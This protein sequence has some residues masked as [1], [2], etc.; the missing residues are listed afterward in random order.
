MTSIMGPEYGRPGHTWAPDADE[1]YN[2]E[3]SIDPNTGQITGPLGSVPAGVALNW[4]AAHDQAVWRRQQQLVRQA[5]YYGQNA[6]GLFESFRPGG[7]AALES[8]IYQSQANISLGQ[9][10]L[11]RPM[12]LLGDWRRDQAARERQRQRKAQVTQQ[13]IGGIGAAASIG[14]APFTG[15]ASLTMLPSFLG[16]AAGAGVAAGGGDMAGTWQQPNQQQP[17]PVGS[18]P[19]A[20][21]GNVG[22]P[23]AGAPMPGPVTPGAGGSPMSPG[24][25]ASFG[26]VAAAGGPSNTRGGQ[27]RVGGGAA[28]GQPQAGAQAGP[29]S[30]QAGPA[31]GG[32]AGAM[33]GL[34]PPVGMDGDFSHLRYSAGGAAALAS[35]PVAMASVN[36][37][38]AELLERDPAYEALNRGIDARLARA[39]MRSV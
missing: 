27:K 37:Y 35:N 2:R 22:G 9:A 30:A 15:G 20:M 23:P 4:Q 32:G 17:G 21:G 13:V 34:I 14:L 11:T 24:T 7:G 36:S 6:L 33:P 12:D 19:P 1:R 10:Q 38:M 25:E 39:L 16:M 31:G 3:H 5:G 18:P 28:P 29:G 26:G 8:G